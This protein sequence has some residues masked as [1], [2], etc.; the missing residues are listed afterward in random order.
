[1]VGDSLTARSHFH[2]S[3]SSNSV[4]GSVLTLGVSTTHAPVGSKVYVRT[5]NDARLLGEWPILSYS[6]TQITCQ[7]DQDCTGASVGNPTVM[8]DALYGD[9]GLWT[10][11]QGYSRLNKRPISLAK[12]HGIPGALA[13]TWTA[14]Q[15]DGRMLIEHVLSANPSDRVF[16]DLGTN[17]AQAAVTVTS[18]ATE[19]AKII[20]AILATGRLL[21]LATVCYLDSGSTTTNGYIKSY[22]GYL[23]GVAAQTSGVTLVEQNT[24]TKDAGGDYST[25]GILASD[26]VHKAPKGARICGKAWADAIASTVSPAT[27]RRPASAAD[28]QEQGGWNLVKNPLLSGTG[29]SHSGGTWSSGNVPDSW[30][31]TVT[32]G[33]VIATQVLRDTGLGYD[34][35]I[36]W[37]TTGAT[38]MVVEQDMTALLPPGTVVTNAGMEIEVNTEGAGHYI[39]PML[40][41]TTAAGEVRCTALRNAQTYANGGRWPTAG[42][43]IYYELPEGFTI[44]SDATDVDFCIYLQAGAAGTQEVA[45]GMPQLEI[46]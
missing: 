39:L 14:I 35:T 24:A 7:L 43:R 42:E 40:Q 16:V 31:V 28:G 27:R 3:S 8:F 21:D 33:T 6:T 36:N 38:S 25:T 18:Y 11:A 20:A 10:Y 29:G 13:S 41:I 2:T 44:P 23:R 4:A 37:T 32:G 45:I 22:N 46:A 19:M 5:A 15:S 12:N 17:D 1:M 34:Y 30:I 9:T 26:N